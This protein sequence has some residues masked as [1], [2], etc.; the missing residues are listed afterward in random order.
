MVEVW[1]KDRPWMKVYEEAGLKYEID[2][3]VIP[4][5]EILDRAARDYPE[6]LSMVYLG[7]EYTYRELS[8]FV[9][10]L[11]TALADLG[12]K[13]GDVVAVQQVNCPQFIIGVY[14]SLKAGATVALLSPL[15]SLDDLK[16]Q[17]QRSRAKI[18]ITEETKLGEIKRIKD[19]TDLEWIT[20]TDMADF[21][22]QEEPIKEV[23]GALQLRKLIEKAEPS[24]PKVEIDPVDDVAVML[25][26]G[27]TT[28][29]PKA[30]M[31]THLNL[32]SGVMQAFTPATG[33]LMD[34]NRGNFAAVGMLP[35]FH[36]FG[37]NLVMNM[38]INWAAAL[39]LVPNP[40]D[41]EMVYR[42]IKDYH[43]FWLHGVPTQFMKMVEEKGLDLTEIRGTV[44]I[45]GAAALPPEVSKKF[46]DRSGILLSEGY[47]HSETSS[48][49]HINFVT[50]LKG[51][52][53][54]YGLPAKLGSIG[55]P[56][57]KTEVEIVDLDTEEPV[58]A[59][60]TGELIVK[61]PQVMKGYWPNPGE[62]LKDGWVYTG[63][64]VRM[65]ED[66][67]FYIVDRTKDMINVS[68]YKV[69]GRVLDDILYEHPAVSEVAVIGIPDPERP[70]SERVK[71]FIT[72]REGY[73]PGKELEEEIIRFCREKLPPYAVPKS[74]E[75]RD[76]LP[77]TVTEKI[78][79]RKLRDEEIAKMGV[80]R[81]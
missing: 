1:C 16:D 32:I 41:V 37:F 13:K 77:L 48:I 24:P 10:K 2:P 18:I 15:L 52:G 14:G 26:A 69:Y 76:E 23:P 30:P 49:T 9:D 53:I 22:L 19:E 67:Y 35:F 33:T 66:G 71:A 40:R 68:G 51:L 79:K 50:A 78:F 62:G 5:Y 12:I 28:G 80:G 44:A 65:D 56:V 27:G 61:G 21:S 17:L 72:P 38:A 63:D 11:A 54:D 8:L 3:P 81:A 74:V 20:I 55:I 46:E 29:I 43:P 34:S 36:V 25:F 57:P 42:L 58:P 75:F 31:L 7:K 4:L 59:G 70:G 64:V 73:Y 47:G 45:S 39:L 60:E 6:S